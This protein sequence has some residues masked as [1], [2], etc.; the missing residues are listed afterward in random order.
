MT[1]HTIT[2][3]T[4]LHISSD[5]LPDEVLVN[6]ERYTPDP[7]FTS[8]EVEM[9]AAPWSNLT[10]PEGPAVTPA[11]DDRGPG[12]VA[13][14]D[15]PVATDEELESHYYSTHGPDLPGALRAIYDLGREHGHRTAKLELARLQEEQSFSRVD[16]RLDKLEAGFEKSK[17]LCAEIDSFLSAS[18]G[19]EAALAAAA[20]FQEEYK[21]DLRDLAKAPDFSLPA[22]VWQRRTMCVCPVC[23]SKCCP[24]ATDPTRYCTGSN[25]PGQE[26]TA[27]HPGDRLV[28]GEDG[29]PVT[30][31]RS[32]STPAPD[33]APDVREYLD[34]IPV[35]GHH[36]H[37]TPGPGDR[38]LWLLMQEAFARSP[39][40][41]L[42]DGLAAELRCV[43]DW[44]QRHEPYQMDAVVAL[45]SEAAR[46]EAG[47]P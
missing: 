33:K 3:T 42:E 32:D 27:L 23:G 47:D 21:D 31:L 43:A 41:D 7:K 5:V 24:K 30:I 25:D 17:T 36:T 45:R 1:N 28:I 46:A 34:S 18:P 35:Y 39:G 9:I 40:D 19:R 11:A 29:T 10:P 14:D 12:S 16:A 8:E 22:D 15:S 38:P 6:G 26:V 13:P 44:L 2:T 20:E 4:T 37:P